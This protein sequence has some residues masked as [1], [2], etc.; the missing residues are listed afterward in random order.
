MP[1]DPARQSRIEEVFHEVVE[2][3]PDQR[4]AALHRLC[5]GDS[6]FEREV[7]ELL[8][9][10]GEAPA[11]FESPAVG[12]F[13]EKQ[14]V[15]E[16]FGGFR[17]IR[18]LGEGGM[19]QVYEAQQAFPSR[20]VALKVIRAGLAGEE[21]Q[22]R[23]E[24]E[25]TALAQL[26]HRGI[27]QIFEAGFIE[28][29]HAGMFAAR[30]P[31]FAM[32]LIDGRRLDEFAG[33]L[34]LKRVLEI[35]ALVADAVQHAHQRGIIHRDLKPGN[36]L[37]EGEG[38]SAQ[39][40]I[41]DFGVARLTPEAAG[42][43][44]LVTEAGQMLGTIAYMAPE[45]FSG[46]DIDTRADVY[47]LGV[48]LYQLL[49]GRL[50]HQTE[51][52]N[53]IESARR[54]TEEDASP[55]GSIRFE[56]RGDVSTIAAKAM[57]R[58]RDRRYAS[59]AELAADLRRFLAN[60]PIQARPATPWYLARKFARRHRALVG[61]AALISAL[62]IAS[63]IGM[64]VLYVREQE[65][66]RLADAALKKS[67]QE[68]QRQRATLSFLVDDAFGAA[69][70]AKKG[71]GLRVVDVLDDA[72]GAVPTRFPDDASLRA[73]MRVHLSDLLCATAQHSKAVPILQQA[74]A[75]AP[76]EDLATRIGAYYQLGECDAYQ[77]RIES[78]LANFRRAVELG[79]NAGPEV[80]GQVQEARLG[81]GHML[82]TMGRLDEAEPILRAL[83]KSDDASSIDR[84]DRPID[85]RI[86]LIECLNQRSGR[87]AEIDQLFQEAVAL[88]HARHLEETPTG[89]DA[90]HNW[91][92]RLIAKGRESEALPIALEVRDAAERIY[93]PT[94]FNVALSN[95]TAGNALVRNGR[96]EDGKAA[97]KKGL[98]ILEST[99]DETQFVIERMRGMAVQLFTRAGDPRTALEYFKQW[100][101]CRL[102]V[103]GAKEG[104]GVAARTRGY[105]ELLQK[106]GASDEQA[107]KA[108][109]DF[110][111]DCRARYGP[112]SE[113]RTRLFSN[114]ARGLSAAPG[115]H[116]VE[117][118]TLLA[119][120]SAALRASKRQD[121]DKAVLE[122][123]TQECVKPG[124]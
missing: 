72:V 4:A 124:G 7:G 18:L 71:M 1:A 83:V 107:S 39:P 40:K 117:I 85:D 64:G 78:A 41:L 34:P 90:L 95:I 121:E 51:K 120:A 45:Q 6:E 101:R 44:T 29:S 102:L 98:D 73:Y 68:V 32:E 47:A 35:V 114:I 56:L 30:R 99:N 5:A 93:P 42:D 20:H 61:S 104:E 22:R 65:Q 108:V 92:S 119:E 25:A 74:L 70:P 86:I 122:A 26:R 21:L 67:N 17:I 66:R 3:P 88:I 55:L 76:P 46:A 63:S 79:Q 109:A 80:A 11:H 27:A 106:Q 75:E 91:A 48:I 31:Y 115:S 33:G 94:H 37:V 43:R 69:A 13:R 59:A 53:L 113:R 100:L 19:G 110:I 81:M 87:D 84:P 118:R 103:A 24:F 89:I 8:R 77:G 62:V 2:S 49:A 54:I 60:E 58:D 16:Q 123:A 15:G 97:F 52:S 14:I 105:F 9:C 10:L 36:I 12:P 96:M 38:A 111:E 116:Q 57:E 28:S 50:P 82:Q 112:E 23:F